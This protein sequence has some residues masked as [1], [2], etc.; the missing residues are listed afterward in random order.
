M[1]KYTSVYTPPFDEFEVE[2][3]V[4]PIGDSYSLPSLTGP[5]I[6]LV[7]KGEGAVTQEYGGS[8]TLSGL[9]VGDIFFVPAGAKVEVS[10]TIDV[11]DGGKGTQVVRG[12]VLELYR[13]RVNN[14][15]V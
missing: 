6:L 15:V 9:K 12:E 11:G 5:S 7:Y 2:R 4:I 3:S 1:D 10:A 8:K 14:R 13:A